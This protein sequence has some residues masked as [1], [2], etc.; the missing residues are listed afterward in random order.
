MKHVLVKLTFLVS[1]LI[2]SGGAFAQDSKKHPELQRFIQKFAQSILDANATE[3]SVLVSGKAASKLEKKAG[4]LKSAS[5]ALINDGAANS[6][7]VAISSVEHK[8]DL[9]HVNAS[10]NGVG[11]KELVIQSNGETMQIVD[12]LGSSQTYYVKNNFSEDKIIGCKGGAKTNVPVGEENG[13]YCGDVDACWVYSSTNFINGSDVAHGC[14]YK[15]TSHIDATIR[16]NGKI[17]CTDKC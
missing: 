16:S 13:L 11:L 4:G 6:I 17:Y 14:Y 15:S 7:E 3:L 12:M 9:F 10:V 1:M 5:K 2:F 8:G